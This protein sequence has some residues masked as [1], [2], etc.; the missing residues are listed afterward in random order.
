MRISIRL[1]LLFSLWLLSVQANAYI[2]AEGEP[3]Q[4]YSTLA[5]EARKADTSESAMESSL[6]RELEDSFINNPRSPKIALRLYNLAMGRGDF[7]LAAFYKIGLLNLLPAGQLRPSDSAALA[8]DCEKV[9]PEIRSQKLIGQLQKMTSELEETINRGASVSLVQAEDY[10]ANIQQTCWKWIKESSKNFLYWSGLTGPGLRTQN[11]EFPA[12]LDTRMLYCFDDYSELRLAGADKTAENY[13]MKMP[14]QL[15]GYGFQE[16]SFP[17]EYPL[18]TAGRLADFVREFRELALEDTALESHSAGRIAAKA[19]IAAYY[20][21]LGYLPSRFLTHF[22][23]LFAFKNAK[24]TWPEILEA[25]T[26]AYESLSQDLIYLEKNFA[27]AWYVRYVIIKA[28]LYLAKL[29]VGI[30]AQPEVLTN[31][32]REIEQDEVQFAVHYYNEG[33]MENLTFNEETCRFQPYQSVDLHFILER[34]K[35]LRAL[36]GRAKADKIHAC[37]EV[38]RLGANLLAK[39]LATLISGLEMSMIPTYYK[40]AKEDWEKLLRLDQ[41]FDFAAQ[42]SLQFQSVAP[43]ISGISN[44][45][46]QD[47]LTFKSTGTYRPDNTFGLPY[48]S[49]LEFSH[50]QG[51]S[52]ELRVKARGYE[53]WP[54]GPLLSG[55]KWDGYILENE[56]RSEGGSGSYLVNVYYQGVEDF[57]SRALKVSTLED[58]KVSGLAQAEVEQTKSNGA[59]DGGSTNKDKFVQTFISKDLSSFDDY[60]A[61]A[62][63]AFHQFRRDQWIRETLEKGLTP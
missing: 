44:Q 48:V 8:K 33:R 46:Y 1:F 50:V 9:N 28:K 35:V 24:D 57:E 52:L 6:W 39:R 2:R 58:L 12:P 13:A 56:A 53:R 40:V 7:A 4:W 49:W 36:L 25:V 22:H 20:R 18:E 51:Q 31:R 11:W 17:S 27:A 38:K 41:E 60:N 55:Q 15:F 42:Y 45:A 47:N 5:E 61:K 14:L 32:L 19:Y 63:R 54:H 21:N 16:T 23:R 10:L 59:V 43:S 3:C 30:S 26:Q 37:I 62:D 34:P 29:W